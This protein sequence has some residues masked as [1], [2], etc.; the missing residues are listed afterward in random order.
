MPHGVAEQNKN[1]AKRIHF[2]GREVKRESGQGSFLYA[3]RSH[4]NGEGVPFMSPHIVCLFLFCFDSLEYCPPC[5]PASLAPILQ[6]SGQ[7]WS[8]ETCC[9]FPVRDSLLGSHLSEHSPWCQKRLFFFFFW[10]N[11]FCIYLGNILLMP[12]IRHIRWQMIIFCK[13][14]CIWDFSFFLIE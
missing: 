4:R 8:S 13:L 9:E 6:D 1:K 10:C 11:N 2:S 7:I 5:P 14:F 12:N 3:G